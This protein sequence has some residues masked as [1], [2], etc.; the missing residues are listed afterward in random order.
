MIL[1][2]NDLHHVTEFTC[3]NCT[4][5]VTM[6]LVGSIEGMVWN[7]IHCP[8]CGPDVAFPIQN[9]PWKKISYDDLSEVKRLASIGKKV[10]A[11]QEHRKITGNGLRESKQ[12]V[13]ELPEMKEY[14]RTRRGHPF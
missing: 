6:G 8:I 4:L 11:I 10:A 1:D 12:F 13:E 5:K 7:V 9:L 14:E 3:G 2:K